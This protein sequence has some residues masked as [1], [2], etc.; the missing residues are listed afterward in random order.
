MDSSC[1]SR[2]P[3]A[4]ETKANPEAEAAPRGGAVN[5]VSHFSPALKAGLPYP[6]TQVAHRR[7]PGPRQEEGAAVGVGVGDG[8]GDAPSVGEGVGS[9]S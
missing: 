3:G 5:D 6:S 2:L 1:C 4:R 7:L 8:S 9:G